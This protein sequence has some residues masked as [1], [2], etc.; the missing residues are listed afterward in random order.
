MPIVV[1]VNGTFACTEGGTA[2]VTAATSVF[3]VGGVDVVVATDVVGSTITG[4]TNTTKICSTVASFVAGAS[5]KLQK[6]GAY[7]LLTGATFLTDGALPAFVASDTQ[8]KLT[9]I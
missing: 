3:Q 4:C 1:T 5:T 2:T 6:G 7:V 9:A 8:T